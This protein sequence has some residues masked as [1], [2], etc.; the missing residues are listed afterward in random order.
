MWFEAECVAVE[1][2]GADSK[3]FRFRTNAP[4]MQRY[5][6]G[7]FV[8]IEAQINGRRVCRSYTLSSTPTRPDGFELGVKRVSDGPF[9]NWICD[10][11]APGDTLRM[12]GPFGEFSCAPRPASKLLLLSAGSG[13]TPMLAMAR[14]IVDRKL[15]V[16]VCFLHI[17]RSRG[18]LMFAKELKQLPREH[19]RLRVKIS[20]SREPVGSPWRGARGRLSAAL[21]RRTASDLPQRSVFLCGPQGFMDDARAL[22]RDAGLPE[23]Q[24]QTESFDVGGVSGSGGDVRFAGTARTVTAGANESLLDVAEAAG[25]RIPSACRTGHCGECKVRCIEGEVSMSLSDGLSAAE[26]EDGYV[27]TCVAAANGNLT[28]AA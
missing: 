22:L 3:A 17:A 8:T 11:L 13:I 9:S 28:L 14:W 23:G 24:L 25:V 18:E 16:D 26:I 12:S 19:P 27:L 5:R 4:A 6:P 7:Q 10:Q 20:L 21:L 2:L 15:D 1:S